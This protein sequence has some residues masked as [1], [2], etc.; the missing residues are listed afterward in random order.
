MT[1][2]P[3]PKFHRY[4]DIFPLLTGE[5]FAELVAD[6]KANGLQNPIV[7]WHGEILDGRNRLLACL[8]AGV[9]PR[10]EEYEGE[11]SRLLEW[12]VSQNLHRRHLLPSQ[13]AL[14]AAEVARPAEGNEPASA[15]NLTEAA[16]RMS[17]NLRH[18][19]YA[20]TVISR[21]VPALVSLVRSGE[22]SIFNADKIA[23]LPPKKQ[24]KVVRGGAAAIEK[25]IKR[26]GGAARRKIFTGLSP[27]SRKPRKSSAK[28]P[29]VAERLYTAFGK[30]I[31]DC[32]RF[33]LE[34]ALRRLPEMEKL[35]KALISWLPPHGTV[36][37]Y[38]SAADLAAMIREA[39]Q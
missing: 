20:R 24:R 12:V 17:V 7:R 8:A 13:R 9:K 35:L 33:E 2:P 34:A 3:R 38:L 26:L 25:E 18:A 29:P 6:I 5:A 1:T 14:I 11:P 32:D 16:A 31:T 21:G 15:V 36:V 39:R 23:M 4:A 27:V 19:Q 30:P 37:E 22:V 10:F 28:V